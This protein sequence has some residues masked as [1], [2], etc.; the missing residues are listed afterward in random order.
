MLT[1]P[2]VRS[3]L[4]VLRDEGFKRLAGKRLGLLVHPPSVD[5][6]FTHAVS[7]FRN[8]GGFE[9]V[10]LFGPQ[11][12]IRGE[13]QDNMI[14]WEGFKDPATGVEVCSL[15][16]QH[17]KPTPAMLSGIDALVIDMQDVG[18]RPYTF[19]WTM[20]LCMQACAEQGVEVVVLDRPNPVAPLGV[21]GPLLD[22]EYKSFVGLAPVPMMHRLTVGELAVFC[23]QRLKVAADL[24]VVWM[25]GYKRSL[26]F[27]ESGLPWV[28]PSPNLPT[29][30]SCLVYPG[31]V[32]FEATNLSEGRGTT[33]PFEVF[34]APFI[35][36]DALVRVLEDWNLPGVLFRP[37][38]FQPTFHKWGGKVCGGA[39]V[40]VL[41]KASLKPMLTAT[42]V[43]CAV[44][45]LWPE[46]FAW[47][48]PPYEYEA[49]KLPIDILAGG[50]GLR[51]AVD[52]GES[53]H[54]IAASWGADEKSF[55]E[56]SAGSLHYD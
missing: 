14:E 1:S 7:L 53:P 37:M 27:E 3:G 56:A 10:R 43:L 26:W 35:D 24:D 41:D 18:A 46:D 38:H 45:E 23:D 42:A 30:E 39:Q 22:M 48:Q 6:R 11:H 36:P 44:R 52:G 21:E 40:H 4:D 25:S 20:L 34:G 33:R 5:G 31:F 28:F 51:E 55:R 15:Y 12:G 29:I 13:T 32:L 16:G 49:A 17:R 50:P 54:S 9:L 47:K 2:V 8:A 19:N